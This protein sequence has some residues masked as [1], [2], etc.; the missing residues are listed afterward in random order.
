MPQPSSPRPPAPL[1]VAPVAAGRRRFAGLALL[2]PLASALGLTACANLGVDRRPRVTLAG[3]EP[4]GGEGLELRVMA[5]LRVQNPGDAPLDYDGVWI[6]L[7]VDGRPLAS[8]GGPVQGR[9]PRYG[10]VVI[11]LPLTVSGLAMVRQALG[12]WSRANAPDGLRAPV[13]YA[14]RGHVGGGAFG[15][16]PFSS[17][18]EVD[19]G[20]A[21]R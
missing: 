1:T 17:S 6:D 4:L 5:R 10:D 19:L 16:V 18:G 21:L 14:L 9:I 3:L 11:S 12:L 15:S 7:D 13:R 20:A 8:G 2:A